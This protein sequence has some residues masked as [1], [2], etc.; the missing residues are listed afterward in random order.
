MI[1]RSIRDQLFKGQSPA[2]QINRA[3]T[4]AEEF[5]LAHGNLSLN[6]DLAS[7]NDNYVNPFSDS[8]MRISGHVNLNLPSGL[9]AAH[10]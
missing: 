5:T 1:H 6:K 9:I 10:G 8:E 4:P 2:A 7:I 3:L